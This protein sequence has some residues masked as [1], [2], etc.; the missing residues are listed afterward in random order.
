MIKISQAKEI[1]T[2]SNDIDGFC[3]IGGMINLKNVRNNIKIEINYKKI[4]NI[5]MQISS[6][7][8]ALAKI[9]D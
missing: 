6:K 8:L 7:L 9:Y 4:Q 1:L 5:N 2:I 3:L